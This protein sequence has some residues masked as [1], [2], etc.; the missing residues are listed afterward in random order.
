MVFVEERHIKSGVK[1]SE[2]KCPVARALKEATLDD[3]WKVCHRLLNEEAYLSLSFLPDVRL[4]IWGFDLGQEVNPFVFQIK[5]PFIYWAGVKIRK[6][7]RRLEE[8]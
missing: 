5:V 8:K 3:G 6:L 2:K 4:F 7:A 1:G